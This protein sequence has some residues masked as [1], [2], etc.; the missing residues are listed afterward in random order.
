M[1]ILFLANDDEGIYKF[2]KEIIE[3][4]LKEN[5]EVFLS[6]PYGKY[7]DYFIGLGCKF[8]DTK[9]DRKG[10][11]PIKDLK[12]ISF[13]RS[14]L[15]EIKPDCVLTYTIKPNVY[16][17]IA[18]QLE[19]TPYIVNITGLGSAVEN[20][21]IL[22]AITLMLYRTGLR[23]AYKVFF[24]NEF[25]KNFMLEKGIIKE[26]VCELIPGS[27]VNLDEFKLMEY[28]NNE[29][30]D[31]LYVGRIMKEKGY[32]QYVDVAKYIRSKY[33][34]TR[35][36][37]CGTY[38]EEEYKTLMDE[39][40]SKG[41]IDYHGSLGSMQGMYELDC[42]T[43]HPSYYPEGLSNVL[44]ESCACGRPVITTNRPGCGELCN[45]GIN[46]FIVKQ[47]DSQ[48]LINKVEKFLS[49]SIEERKQMGINGRKLIENNY[50][51]RMV[52][53]KYL[54]AINNAK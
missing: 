47:E 38:D 26:N 34:N 8:I 13:Y 1:K 48:D 25:N 22:Q 6:L 40:T 10:T 4:L 36:H 12:Q 28:P 44:L 14:I 41:I 23:K 19:N 27:G 32:L 50:D 53:E 24:Q 11:N 20:G 39:L 51:R 52:I 18:C 33:P 43:I 21:G 29:T 31:F 42:C 35:F 49:L 9:F 45:D 16:G 54:Q 46:G 17:G 2:R 15:K 5:N 37:I 3:A 7:V 30:I